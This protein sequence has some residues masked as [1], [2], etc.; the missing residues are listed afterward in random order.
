MDGKVATVSTRIVEKRMGEDITKA[1]TISG[2]PQGGVLSSLMWRL[3][4]DELLGYG[5]DIVFVARGKLK[6][7][8]CR[9]KSGKYRAMQWG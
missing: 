4:V 6:G 9:H 7:T 2:C 5:D 1:S 3:V 8:L